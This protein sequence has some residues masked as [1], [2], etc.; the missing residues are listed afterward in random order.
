MEHPEK[1]LFE[2]V[3]ALKKDIQESKD[4]VAK[5][6]TDYDEKIVIFEKR[7]QINERSE[8]KFRKWQKLSKKT[9]TF[10]LDEKDYTFLRTTFENNIYKVDSSFLQEDGNKIFIDAQKSFFKLFM[11]IIKKGNSEF[12]RMMY[13]PNAR[14]D[15][16]IMNSFAKEFDRST[17]EDQNFLEFIREIF[18]PKSFFDVVN[19]FNIGLEILPK[20]DGSDLFIKHEISVPYKQVTLSKFASESL[21][22][23]SDKTSLN[24]FFLGYNGKIDIELA[25]LI[26]VRKIYAKPFCSDSKLWNPVTGSTH[27]QIYV[28]IDGNNWELAGNAPSK[29][30]TST[31][32]FISVIMLNNLFTFKFIR[33]ATG[34]QSLFSLKY[35]AFKN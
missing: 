27:T 24:A 32:N 1:A 6:Q 14:E 33:F 16:N 28:S 31:N 17:R 2:E 22:T 5:L 12:N 30:G 15:L 21:L 35:L 18:E 11:V 8:D 25:E 26:R 19:H 20:K 3:L 4:R 10:L 23:L 9:V 7:R 34:N 13:D 29:Y